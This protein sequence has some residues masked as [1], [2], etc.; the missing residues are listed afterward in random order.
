MILTA[1]KTTFQKLRP[2]VIN[3]RD[4]EYLDNE[5]Y[6]ID[7]LM[8]ICNSCPRFDD[9]G[10]IEFFDLRRVTFDAPRKQKYARDNHMPF[11]NKTLPKE[12]MKR[13]KLRNKFLKDKT[14]ENEKKDIRYINIIVFQFCAKR[15]KEYCRNLGE[16]KVSNNK[17][18][19][20]TVKHFLLNEIVSEKQITL[21]ENDKIIWED[22]DVAQSLSSF[23]SSIET[24]LIIHEYNENDSNS[25]NITDPITNIILKYRNHP[26]IFT[27]EKVCKERSI[28]PF[29]FSEVC[30]EEILKDI[31]N[32][33]SSNL[34][35]DTDVPTRDVKENADI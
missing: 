9:S 8:E 3:Y 13:T 16:K 19:W 27:I 25:K 21:I 24:N 33:H 28:G 15:K 29:S 31:L 17:I 23:F 5:N 6:R 34:C 12:I 4:Y 35:Q 1:T 2:R 14:Y 10:F 30:K 20:K 26:S 7:L 11:I 18:F 22:S 32:F